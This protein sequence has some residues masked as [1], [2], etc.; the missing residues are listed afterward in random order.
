MAID[1]V[2]ADIDARMTKRKIILPT[3]VAVSPNVD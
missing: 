3:L 1:E 2:M